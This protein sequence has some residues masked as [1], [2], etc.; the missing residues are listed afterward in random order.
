[1]DGLLRL[2]FAPRADLA[3]RGAVLPQPA[4]PGGLAARPTPRRTG[5]LPCDSA[6][7]VVARRT[8]K[9]RHSRRDQRL[10]PRGR[11]LATTQRGFYQ[12]ALPRPRAAG[13]ARRGTSTRRR[14]RR[15]VRDRR[16]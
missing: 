5:A 2:G 16:R 1:M 6:Y 15:T 7:G 10:V 14:L 11:R 8:G 4:D 12:A 9:G 13:A 3:R